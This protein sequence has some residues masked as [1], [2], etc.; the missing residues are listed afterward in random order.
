[1]YLRPKPTSGSSSATRTSIWSMAQ[2]MSAAR[3][4][5]ARATWPDVQDIILGERGPAGHPHQKNRV[6][7]SM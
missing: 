2:S 3:M 4:R 7:S 1:M 5:R 6:G